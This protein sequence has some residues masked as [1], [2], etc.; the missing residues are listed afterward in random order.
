MAVLNI[1]LYSSRKNQLLTYQDNDGQMTSEIESVFVHNCE[2]VYG[3]EKWAL[4]KVCDKTHNALKLLEDKYD[5]ET[6]QY[7]RR[8]HGFISKMQDEEYFYYMNKDE[9]SIVERK[10]AIRC[11]SIFKNG[12][13]DVRH[14]HNKVFKYYSIFNNTFEYTSFGFDG[15]KV[16]IGEKEKENRIC[17]FCGGKVPEVTF[18]KIAHA[19]QDALGNKLLFCYEECDKCNHDLAPIEDNFRKLMDFRR[20]IYHI[21]RKGTTKTPTVIGKNFIIKAD[22]NGG[23][24]LYLMEEGLPKG[25]NKAKRFIHHLDLAAT[26]T[27]EKMY[28]ALCKVVIDML[29]SSELSHFENTIRWIRSDEDMVSDALPSALLTVLPTDE[30]IYKQPVLDILLNKHRHLEHSPYCT[31]IIWIYDIAYMFCMPLTDVDRGMYKYDKDLQQHWELMC[32]LTGINGW[33]SQNTE[34]YKLSTPWVNWDINPEL[35]NIHILPKSNPIFS[36][37]FVQEIEIKDAGLPVYDDAGISLCH[38]EA[39]QFTSLYKGTI[40][41]S[42]L[43]DVTNHI[44]GPGFTLDPVKKQIR[45]RMW[46]D[47]NDTTDKIAYFKIYFDVILTVDKFWTYIDMPCDKDGTPKSFTLH[48]KLRDYL[49]VNALAY[50]ERELFIQRRN[51]QFAKCSLGKLLSS[52][53]IFTCAYYM[54]PTGNNQEYM[55]VMDSQIHN[56]MDICM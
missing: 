51:T 19:I 52:R 40:S 1:L 53:R 36:E 4:I 2:I 14:I 50:A 46:I 55:K 25:V 12:A 42:D 31:A 49:F 30:V 3:L 22:N 41:D 5:V 38:V 39:A 33:E 8:L 45:V 27:N 24:A 9:V 11:L 18:D 48:Y 43:R 47:A 29:P 7:I 15:I 35:P 28:K 16:W 23:P 44:G 21:P 20:A 56:G 6:R 54:I 26:M 13:M 34:D 37:C 17:R 32:K 10:T